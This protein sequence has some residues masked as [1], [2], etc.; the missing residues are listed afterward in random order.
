M[1]R[2]R[3][4]RCAFKYKFCTIFRQHRPGVDR[5]LRAARCFR[6]RTAPQFVR[7]GASIERLSEARLAW[8]AHSGKMPQ[9]SILLAKAG[10]MKTD[11][12]IV[13]RGRGLQLS[14]S[15]ITVQAHG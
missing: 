9:E 8:E 4:K 13:E 2:G 12:Q 10:A 5:L 3:V 15:R 14:T 11:I 6:Q 1:H 7:F